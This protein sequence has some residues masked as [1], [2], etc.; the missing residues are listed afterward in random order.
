MSV[1]ALLEVVE[2]GDGLPDIDDVLLFDETH[3]DVEL[4]EFRLAIGAKI[5]IAVTPSDLEIPLDAA[6]HQQLLEQLGRLRERVPV[7]GLQAHGHEEISRSLG[8]GSGEGRG[9]DLHEAAIQ[10]RRAGYLINARTHTNR[11]TRLGPT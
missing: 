5:F 11:V 8:G 2:E 6:D 7:A 9:F 3:L 10:E 4:G 1:Q